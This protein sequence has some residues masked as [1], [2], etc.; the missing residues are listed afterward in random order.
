MG[1]MEMQI[2]CLLFAAYT[3]STIPTVQQLNFKL[4]RVSII[5]E[6]SV[7]FFWLDYRVSAG[8]L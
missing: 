3:I 7:A 8:M 2:P 4:K 6:F 5:S 1:K